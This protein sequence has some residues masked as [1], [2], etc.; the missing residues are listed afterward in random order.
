V[1]TA[2]TVSAPTL[3]AT[4]EKSLFESSGFL[5]AL[6]VGDVLL[7]IVAILLV[8]AVMRKKSQ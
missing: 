7:V 4:G 5:V 1:I 8:A 6:V 3:P 2:G